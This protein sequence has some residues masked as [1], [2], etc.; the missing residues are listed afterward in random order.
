MK[1]STE[2]FME[3]G[4]SLSEAAGKMILKDM[5]QKGVSVEALKEELRLREGFRTREDVTTSSIP[6]EWSIVKHSLVREQGFL[7]GPVAFSRP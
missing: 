2:G 6:E 7:S 5:L 1:R 4:T 3:F